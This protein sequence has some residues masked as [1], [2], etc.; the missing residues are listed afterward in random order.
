MTI[1]TTEEVRAYI[2]K[3]YWESGKTKGKSGYENFFINW[4]WN[5]RL[6]ECLEMS[7]INKKSKILDLGCAYGQVVASLLKKKYDV[8]GIDISDYA[9]EQGQK[10]YPP[11]KGKTFQG[12]CHQL[13]RFEDS[14][15]DFL[16]SQQVFEHIPASVCQ[17]LAEETYRITKP[18]GLIWAGLV[19]D[20]GEDYQPQGFNP[21][22]P[23]K[24]HIN[25]RPKQWWDDI[26]LSVGWSVDDDSDKRFRETRLP[27]GYSFFEEYGW[28]S[29]CYKKG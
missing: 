1:K 16:Y 25:L 2:Q 3:D 13:Q 14:S 20:L 15:F 11:L 27:D 23:D 24:T 22:D 8:N 18:K 21:E 26:F 4:N 10:E 7:L 28:H 29:L 17:K 9:I 5:N 12:S 6:T 19:L